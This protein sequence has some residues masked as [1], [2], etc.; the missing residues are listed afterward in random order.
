MS[1]ASEM[2]NLLKEYFFSYLKSKNFPKIFHW[3]FSYMITLLSSS[4]EFVL[5]FRHKDLNMR[6]LMNK[7]KFYLFFLINN[8]R[9]YR[10]YSAL[11]NI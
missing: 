7:K 1:F 3:F 5:R 2:V 9:N 4:D 10:N 11:L 6:N 8:Y